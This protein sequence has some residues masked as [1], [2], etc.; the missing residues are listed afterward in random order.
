[1][2]LVKNGAYKRH[3]PIQI[4]CKLFSA[5]SLLDDVVCTESSASS[6]LR[7]ATPVFV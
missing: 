6:P 5:I 4:C 7:P 1:M 2:V 3:R